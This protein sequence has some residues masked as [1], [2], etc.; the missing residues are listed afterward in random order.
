MVGRR[1]GASV[2]VGTGFRLQGG[3]TADMSD[4]SYTTHRTYTG[5]MGA[6]SPAAYA[7]LAK[8]AAMKPLKSG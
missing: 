3:V 2:S 8:Q 6:A 7:E 5:P 4:G 1:S